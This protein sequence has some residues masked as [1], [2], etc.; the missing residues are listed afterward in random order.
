MNIGKDSRR[1]YGNSEC[2]WVI[3]CERTRNSGDNIRLHIRK[4]QEKDERTRRWEC[5]CCLCCSMMMMTMVM[6]IVL[7]CV[8]AG[9][10]VGWLVMKMKDREKVGGTS[11]MKDSP[12]VGVWV[13]GC[14]GHAR[15]ENRVNVYLALPSLLF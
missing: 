6:I 5:V 9:W 4:E 7:G 11:Y 15:G 1:G 12:G 13:L 14:L 3:P 10:L 2:D 8:L